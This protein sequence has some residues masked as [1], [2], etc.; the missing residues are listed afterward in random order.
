MDFRPEQQ[1]RP[2]QHQDGQPGRE[3]AMQP[4]PVFIRENYRGSGRLENRIAL[5]TSGDSGIGRA[6]AV[7][8]RAKARTSPSRISTNI[9]MP[10]KRSGWC[11]RRDGAASC[12]Q[13]M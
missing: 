11:K 13:A 3:D 10:K 7:H 12:L 8:Y 6:V 2:P 5:I 4:R 9:A 1:A